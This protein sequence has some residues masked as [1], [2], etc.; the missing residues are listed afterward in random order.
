MNPE[1]YL[2]ID[3]LFIA[4]C[5]AWTASEI[6]LQFVKRTSRSR[7]VLKDRGSLLLLMPVIFASIT[8]AVWYGETHTRNILGGA[9]WLRSTA[10]VLLVIGI[11][12]RAT[13]IV[14]LGASFSTNVAIHA[15]QTLRKTGLYKW[16][17]HP[18]YTGALLAFVSIGLFECNWLSL[19][20][21][22]V[23]PTAVM[24]Y[25]IHVEEMALNEA[26]GD[27]YVE[28]SNVTKR[29]VPGIY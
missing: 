16:I 8:A 25:R 14:T 9:L 18:S 26:F 7:G 10:L 22:A 20:I 12:I 28:Y 29:L 6:L 3:R 19:A 23:F 2:N 15:T 13:A 1:G 24:L 11:V 27:A 5:W 4:I 21:M 17:R